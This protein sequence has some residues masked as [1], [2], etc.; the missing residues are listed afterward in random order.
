MSNSYQ[1]INISNY[2]L[3][4]MV[5]EIFGLN[6]K[7]CKFQTKCLTLDFSLNIK[8]KFLFEQSLQTRVSST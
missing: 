3:F 6:P 2:R 4:F 5:Y 8:T 7:K 1:I